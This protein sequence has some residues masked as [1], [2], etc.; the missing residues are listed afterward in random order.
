MSVAV[1]S[2]GSERSRQVILAPM[3]LSATVYHLQIDLSDVDRGVYEALDLRVARHPSESMPYMLTRVLAYALLFEE[4]IAF[5]KGLSTADE[6]ALWVRDLQGNLRV[7]VEIGTPSADRL[8]KASKASPRVVVFTHHDPRHLIKEAQSRPIH[9][10]EQIE[11]YAL[12]PAFLAELEAL[13]DRN[14]RWTLLRNDGLLY[15]TVG[16]QTVSSAVSRQA[17]QAPQA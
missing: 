2:R 10:A 11:V 16:E 12:A 4:G 14:V 5:S 13:M 3:A 9:K 17:L 6:P 8:H 15:V 7:W 1:A